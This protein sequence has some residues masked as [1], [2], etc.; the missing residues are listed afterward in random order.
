MSFED[1]IKNWVALDDKI[2]Q[3]NDGVKELRKKKS[4]IQERIQAYVEANNLH[5]ATIQISD[6]KL[7]F[8]TSKVTS[9][10]TLK[11]VKECLDSCIA[12]ES[13]VEKIMTIIKNNREV[14][15]VEDIKRNYD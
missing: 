2:K 1:D 4:T 6:G 7:K 8:H 9:P 14:K 12:N 13:D 15:M 10:L 3:Y 11:Y 5:H